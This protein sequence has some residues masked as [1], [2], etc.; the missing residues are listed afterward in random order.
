MHLLGF[1]EGEPR[2]RHA[3]NSNPC[4]RNN[5]L[6]LLHPRVREAVIQVQAGL[7]SE[8]IPFRAFEA[9]R[10]PE[11]QADLYAQGRTKPGRIVRN[12]FV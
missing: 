4:A 7:N 5:D 8:G 1:A 9:F 2:E 3:A 12:N 6:Q 10:F 11:R